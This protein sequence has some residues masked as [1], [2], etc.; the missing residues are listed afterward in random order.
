M[1][2]AKKQK[3][4]EFIQHQI[5][6]AEFRTSGYVFSALDQQKKH[7]QRSCFLVL[8][9]YLNRYIRKKSIN[10][11]LILLYGLRGTGKTTLLSQIYHSISIAPNRKLFL[12]VDEIVGVL[13]ADLKDV[14]SVYEEILGNS[15][16]ALPHPVFLFL[17]E[18]HFDSKWSLVLKTIY[19]RSQNVFIFATGSSAL[20]LQTSP[21]LE[22]RAKSIKLYP[23]NFT[24][25]MKVRY[26]KFEEKGLSKEI[27]EVLFFSGSASEVY[28][29]LKCVES[30]TKRYWSTIQKKEV[31]IYMN[32]GTLPFTLTSQ[33]E[34]LVYDQIKKILDRVVHIDISHIKEF[35]PE[36]ILKIPS[37]LYALAS[38]D[39][40]SLTNLSNT[41]NISRPTL[42]SVLE[43]LE[44]TET[45][46]R[47]QSYGSHHHQ[48]RKPSKY[49]FTSPAFRSMYFNMIESIASHGKYKGMLFEDVVGLTL[50]RFFSEKPDTSITY[51]VS[52][53]GADF[54][55]RCGKNTLVV[56]AGYGVKTIKQVVQTM[57][58]VPASYGIV[59]SQNQLT[60]YTDENIVHVPF[61]YFLLI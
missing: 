21:D 47:L 25:Y 36:I 58:R 3:I 61:S 54:I 37:I 53:G 56:E 7:P 6:N 57:K 44:M 4:F 26:D 46:W 49:L 52:S 22:R 29:G 33:S 28:D 14:L 40:T 20:S 23:M 30:L 1:D 12:S 19:D 50:R 8:D 45:I 48:I 51:D 9:Q 24:E 15:F 16:E 41:T 32:Y 18:V 42:A 59:V 5:V 31:D 2:A 11:R 39:Q 55:I 27:R 38:S 13:G 34:S 60:C 10:D 17:D 35:S 43:T